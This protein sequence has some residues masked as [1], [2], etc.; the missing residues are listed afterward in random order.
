MDSEKL[1]SLFWI[2]ECE[3]TSGTKRE[4]PN[5]IIRRACSMTR[6]AASPGSI[7]HFPSS[8]YSHAKSAQLVH[9]DMT[10]RNWNSYIHPHVNYMSARRWPC[11]N[12][13]K[14]SHFEVTHFK[15][16][17]NVQ[18]SS[19]CCSSTGF[20]PLKHSKQLQCICSDLSNVVLQRVEHQ[21]SF[22]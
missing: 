19:N 4:N 21:H 15:Y 17:K 16:L 3:I 11:G 18:P 8:S 12:L 14:L 13:S 20:W 22:A 10:I 2:E 1:Q 6:I 7:F 5:L 9:I